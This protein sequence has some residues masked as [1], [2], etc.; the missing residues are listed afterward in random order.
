MDEREELLTE[1]IK[2]KGFFRTLGGGF[3]TLVDFFDDLVAKCSDLTETNYRLAVDMA[4]RGQVDDAILRFRITLWLAPDHVPSLYNL[5]CLYHHKRMNNKAL[6]CF[7]KVIQRVPDHYDAIFM[8]ASMDPSM[9]KAEILPKTMPPEMAIEYFDGLAD[10]YDYVQQA[11]VY[12]LP[13]L[14]HQ[15]LMPELEK[16]GNINNLIDLGCGTGLCGAQFREQFANLVGVDFSNR[17]LDEAYR[18]MDRRGV[19]IYTR[20]E[21]QDM[22]LHFQQEK[23][24]FFD[25]AL[26]LSVLPYLGDLEALFAGVRLVLQQGGWFA[27]SFDPYKINGNPAEGFG[28]MPQTGYF[29]HDLRYVLQRAE[30]Y[31]FE[32]MRTGEVLSHPQRHVQLCFFRKK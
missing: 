14:T 27:C 31:G 26:C 16:A 20:L 7:K 23:E 19:K 6:D 4:R 3:S 9:I 29:G 28:M 18:K 12:Q 13:A 15:L 11:N 5:G 10:Q 2:R 21:H 8:V 25:V 22:R 17:M 24:A 32:S 30:S 1:E